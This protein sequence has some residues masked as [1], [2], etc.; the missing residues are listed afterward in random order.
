MLCFGCLLEITFWATKMRSC[1]KNDTKASK[2]W[3][4]LPQKLNEKSLICSKL[5][6]MSN[7]CWANSKYLQF[8]Q[9]ITVNKVSRCPLMSFNTPIF[10][11]LFF[12]F[13][14]SCTQ[15]TLKS[16]KFSPPTSCS[17]PPTY[18]SK[19][20]QAKGMNESHHNVSCAALRL[21][22]VQTP[23]STTRLPPP[24]GTKTEISQIFLRTLCQNSWKF[25]V[26]LLIFYLKLWKINVTR[27][28]KGNSFNFFCLIDLF[29]A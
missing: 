9:W 14:S 10:S 19:T 25:H 27:Q 28:G 29:Q 5:W 13:L 18:K 24:E 1:K 12:L 6:I 15:Q 3:Y 17:T 4:W 2:N 26:E 20:L 7:H 21:Q 11:L 16:G 22:A 23:N 8:A